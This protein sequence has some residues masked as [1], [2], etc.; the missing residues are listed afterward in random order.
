MKY[1]KKFEKIK[2]PKKGDYIILL[3]DNSDTPYE[4]SGRRF[5]VGEIY[6]IDIIDP[7]PA[8]GEYKFRIKNI[9]P[10]ADTWI[11]LDQF[12]LATDEEI[13]QYNIEQQANKYNL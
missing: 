8:A 12:R 3:K 1:L 10:Y 2:F 7:T 5:K 13:E 9:S 11:R 4:L 6:K